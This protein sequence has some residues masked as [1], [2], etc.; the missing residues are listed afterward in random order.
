ML[1]SLQWVYDL[2]RRQLSVFVKNTDGT[3]VKNITTGVIYDIPTCY[4]DYG[5]VRR[6][7]Y[8]QVLHTSGHMLFDFRQ[9]FGMAG[10][11]AFLALAKEAKQVEKDTKRYEKLGWNDSP[12]DMPEIDVYQYMSDSDIVSATKRAEP[13]VQQSP[14]VKRREE[15][16]LNSNSQRF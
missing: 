6:L 8:N 15:Q 2:E 9:I 7:D 12:Y 10:T 5:C 4:S 11:K 1:S 13:F 16:I 3:R 14:E